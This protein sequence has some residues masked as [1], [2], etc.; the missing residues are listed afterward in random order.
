MGASMSI[1]PFATKRAI[2]ARLGDACKR[3]LDVV[4]IREGV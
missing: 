4:A 2:V 3:L 1:F